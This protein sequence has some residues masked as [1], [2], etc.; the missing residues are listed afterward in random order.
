MVSHILIGTEGSHSSL[1]AHPATSKKRCIWSKVV[2]KVLRVVDPHKWD[3]V[4]DFDE[5]PK[6]VE[7]GSLI[8]IPL[9]TGIPINE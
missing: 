8:I 2:G 3:I 7:S 1:I 4:F 6:T 9:E 5:Q